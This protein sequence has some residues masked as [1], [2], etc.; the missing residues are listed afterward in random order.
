MTKVTSFEDLRCWKKA[1]TLNKEIYEITRTGTLVRDYIFRDQLRRA[2]IS[3]SSNIAEGFS[4]FHRKDSNRFYDF[5]QSSAAEV[6]SLIY[7]AW[8]L[9]Y[10]QQEDAEKLIEETKHCKNMILA[11][12]KH[13]NRNLENEQQK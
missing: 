12:I 4:R 9:K 3:I 2:A 13:N 6:C 11:L 5:A 1:R 10:I 8:D 7:L